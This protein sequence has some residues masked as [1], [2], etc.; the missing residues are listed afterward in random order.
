MSL[1]ASGYIKTPGDF[2]TE[3]T[4]KYLRSKPVSSFNVPGVDVS[5]PVAVDKVRQ[6]QASGLGS[7]ADLIGLGLLGGGAYG[8]VRHHGKLKKTK[9][10]L[11]KIEKTRGSVTYPVK[12]ASNNPIV[13]G[14]VDFVK[15]APVAA[16]NY[17]KGLASVDP[18]IAGKYDVPLGPLP[19][20]WAIPV[21]GIGVPAA[22]IA[23]ERIADTAT[24]KLRDKMI[25]ERKEKL[26]GQFS[27][28]LSKQSERDASINVDTASCEAL[29]DF[30]APKA[31]SMITKTS[32]VQPSTAAL[33]GLYSWWILSSLLAWNR[34][35]AIASSDPGKAEYKE[36]DKFERE[37]ELGKPVRFRAVSPGNVLPA[38]RLAYGNPF[39]LAYPEFGGNSLY[40]QAFIGDVKQWAGDKLQ[41]G[42]QWAVNTAFEQFKPQIEQKAQEMV[43]SKLGIDLSDP[44]QTENIQ[45][46]VKFMQSAGGMWDKIK[47][48]GSNAWNMIQPAIAKFI[49]GAGN[50][51]ESAGRGTAQAAKILGLDQDNQ[52]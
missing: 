24:D 37:S 19:K 31:A 33:G 42:K 52:K 15:V 26:K 35:K 4:L 1:K 21:L 51:A 10:E 32:N 12:Q 45:S 48:F 5:D 49:S 11:D 20:G 25:K 23:G 17:I 28:L 40:K 3:L 22:F 34:G 36:L 7:I 27:R 47:S 13:D 8:L 2:V 38:S 41:A 16:W 9:E 18:N 39:P 46:A 43:S 29:L 14:I 44:K 30:I 50:V 6:L